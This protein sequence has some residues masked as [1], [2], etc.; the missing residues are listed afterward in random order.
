MPIRKRGFR[1]RSR[2]PFI[3]QSQKSCM[4]CLRKVDIDYKNTTLL[5]KFLSE[6]GKILSARITGNCAKHQRRLSQ[7]I[8]RARVIALLPFK[9]VYEF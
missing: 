3:S 2:R 7:A 1:G 6:R 8:K 9:T 5:Q 4:F